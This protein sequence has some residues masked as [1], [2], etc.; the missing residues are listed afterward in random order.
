MARISG[1]GGR[2]RATALDRRRTVVVKNGRAGCGGL[3]TGAI[4][5]PSRRSRR[6]VVDST[7]AGDSF[8]AGF[9]AAWLGG[10]PLRSD[11]SRS[12]TRAGALSTRGGRRHV[13]ASRPWTR[14]WKRWSGIR[15]VIVC[16]AANPSIDKLF[17]V[18]PSGRRG[19]PSPHRVR[20]DGRRQGVERRPRGARPRA[21]TCG[22]WR[23]CR[24]HG[25]VARRRRF[26]PRACRA[27]SC[28]RTARTGPR[29]PSPTGR[30]ARSPSSTRAGPRCRPRRVARTGRR[31]RRVL[32]GAATWL[33]ISRQPSRGRPRLGVRDLVAEARAGGVRVALDAEGERLR[34][35]LEARARR[36]EGE[37]RGGR[38]AAGRADG[39]ARRSDGRGAEAPR[40]GRRRRSR[41]D[42]DARCRRRGGRR[43]RRLALR[44]RAVRARAVPVG[45]GDAFLAGLVVALERG[46]EWGGRCGSRSGRRPRTPSC[47]APVA[48][49]RRVRWRS[50]SKRR[51]G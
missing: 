35:A 6:Q 1:R 20:A 48:W 16:L 23:C 45:S 37:R 11:A 30:P 43:A 44:G 31:D 3:V 38:G 13:D 4:G 26:R 7:G 46:E 51:S 40:A 5:P 42:R 32:S 33:T 24:A 18:E 10:E 21:G 17:E 2:D 28:G 25:Q 22:R 8:D 41:R 47:P 15:A 14:P 12:A 29:C 39:P 34:L 9:L 50:P 27:R 19:H 49:T 36:R